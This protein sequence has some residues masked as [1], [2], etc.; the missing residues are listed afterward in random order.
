MYIFKLSKFSIFFHI[1]YYYKNI[2]LSGDRRN[3]P[4]PKYAPVQMFVKLTCEAVSPM[5]V[6]FPDC[7]NGKGGNVLYPSKGRGD[8][9]G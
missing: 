7:F 8:M 2:R 9:S 5:S 3:G 4:L 6:W 1:K